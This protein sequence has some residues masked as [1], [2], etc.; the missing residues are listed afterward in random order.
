MQAVRQEVPRP[1]VSGHARLCGARR[2]PALRVR[3]LPQD[4][5]HARQSKHTRDRGSRGQEAA[6]V[7]G[8]RLQGHIKVCLAEAYGIEAQ[9]W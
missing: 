5:R 3:V 8:V 6:P 9:R 2:D 7:Q 4:V 1:K